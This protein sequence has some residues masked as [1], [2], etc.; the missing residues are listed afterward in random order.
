MA[1]FNHRGGCGR[2]CGN[3][4]DGRN[5]MVWNHGPGVWHYLS[6]RTSDHIYH[7]YHHHD[8]GR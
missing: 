3:N 6:D 8:N 5:R 2:T 7:V 4:S 1:R